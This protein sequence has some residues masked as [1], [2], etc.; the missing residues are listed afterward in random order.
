M[1]ID[2]KVRGHHVLCTLGF[3][4]LGYSAAFVANMRRIVDALLAEP[5]PTV[6]LVA[7]P[8]AVCSACP[9]LTETGCARKE[10]AEARIRAK[11][12]AVLAALRA[13]EGA[14]LAAAELR[15]RVAQRVSV[16]TLEAFCRRCSWWGY[17]YCAEGLEALRRTHAG[18]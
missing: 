2:L 3:R 18:G 15:S 4:G 8:D 16:A 17:G 10:D 5:S 1:R 13:E 6:E 11:D 14:S 7:G 9:H 12:R